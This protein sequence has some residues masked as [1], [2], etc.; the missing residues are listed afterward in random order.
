VRVHAA[1]VYSG[2]LPDGNLIGGPFKSRPVAVGG[3]S[4]GDDAAVVM[5]LDP[6]TLAP[7]LAGLL[8]AEAAATASA[9]VDSAMTKV[10]ASFMLASRLFTDKEPGERGHRSGLRSTRRRIA[11]KSGRECKFPEFR[12]EAPRWRVFSPA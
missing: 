12:A 8:C 5:P 2:V 11:K 4:G 3:P 7:E 9:V 10:E 6:V 1:R